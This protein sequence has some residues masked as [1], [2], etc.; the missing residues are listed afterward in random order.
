[1]LTSNSPCDGRALQLHL[2]RVT[3]RV[4]QV[5][6]RLA[7]GSRQVELEKAWHPMLLIQA[8]DIPMYK[9]WLVGGVSEVK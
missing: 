4:H 7:T 5:Q 6:H 3:P 8:V 9:E 1:M 2:E